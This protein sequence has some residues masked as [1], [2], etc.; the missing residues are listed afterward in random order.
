[1]RYDG[2]TELLK[3]APKR[4]R[5]AQELLEEPTRD[6]ETSDAEYRHLCGAYY[7]AGYAVECAL[8][9]YIIALLNARESSS[10]TR[11][12]EAIALIR[13]S[14]TPV[15][16]SGARS[17]SL[18]RLLDAAQLEAQ[19]TSDH[20]MKQNWAIC[21]KWDYNE[22]Y[23]PEPMVNRRDVTEFVEACAASYTWVRN[24]L[25]FS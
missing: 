19:M 18:D 2:H 6:Q 16:M 21:R 25:P 15:D 7:L 17:H 3:A 11:W 9:A 13:A 1:M 4:L 12:S 23:R 22:R 14:D 5:D 8:K 24:R 10:V 20:E